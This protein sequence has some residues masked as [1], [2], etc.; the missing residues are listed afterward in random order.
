MIERSLRHALWAAPRT[1]CRTSRA[2]RKCPPRRLLQPCR[3]L[4]T[5]TE[6]DSIGASADNSFKQLQS[7]HAQLGAYGDT[8]APPVDPETHAT[9]A[10]AVDN[11]REQYYMFK[12]MGP[13]PQLPH[14]PHPTLTPCRAAD[15]TPR[16]HHQ[17]PLPTS[18]APDQPAVTG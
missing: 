9:A 7:I 11:V 13:P 3:P 12:K 15:E 4:S 5:T 6:A 10:S 14:L 16:H 8:T 18:H 2:S 17:A 1:V